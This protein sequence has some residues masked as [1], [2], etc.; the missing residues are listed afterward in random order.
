MSETTSTILKYASLMIICG[1][2]GAVIGN[3]WIYMPLAFFVGW[4]WTPFWN[5]IT[6]GYRND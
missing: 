1:G 2:L 4:N 5:A 3:P 6:K